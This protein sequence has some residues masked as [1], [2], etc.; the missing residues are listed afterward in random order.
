MW[1]HSLQW[2]KVLG[3]ARFKNF[4][5]WSSL[6]E[7]FYS[8]VIYYCFI[9]LL[10]EIYKVITINRLWNRSIKNRLWKEF[11]KTHTSFLILKKKNYPCKTQTKIV[12]DQYSIGSRN[13]V[14]QTHDHLRLD[15]DMKVEFN[16]YVCCRDAEVHNSQKESESKEKILCLDWTHF[17]FI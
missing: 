13:W 11:L 16:G 1:N 3:N 8:C 9:L 5:L 15:F 12:S 2:M 4:L 10:K 17:K 7:M 6:F 14:N